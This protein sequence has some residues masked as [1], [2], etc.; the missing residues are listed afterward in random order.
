MVKD[1]AS[2]VADEQIL[3]AVVIIVAGGNSEAES[4]VF[5]EQPG[6][7]GDILEGAVAAVA[8]QA[9][10]ESGIGLLHFRQLGAV[11]EEKIHAAVVVEVEGGHS[12][13][14]GLREILPAGEVI[15]RPISEVGFGSDIGEM[16][17]PRLG[18]LA[19]G[20]QPPATKHQPPGT[21]H[22]PPSH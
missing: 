9:V 7:R 15:V 12:A 6:A 18:P 11:G 21:S 10:V 3:E 2:G 4:E 19:A 13:A 22:Q 14:H 8:Q 5:A 17:A 16:G 1:V 20:R